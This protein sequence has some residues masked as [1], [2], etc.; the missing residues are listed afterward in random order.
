[1]S[2]SPLALILAQAVFVWVDKAGV[3]HYTNDRSSIPRG[4]KVTQTEGDEIST[5]EVGAPSPGP[6]AAPAVPPQA[7]EESPA[8]RRNREDAWRSAF[9]AARTAIVEIEAEVE[10]ER[11]QVEEVNGMPVTGSTVC[12]PNFR[13]GRQVYGLPQT[14]RPDNQRGRQQLE[15]NRRRLERAKEDLASLQRR[16]ANE[17]V[18]LEWRQ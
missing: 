7:N 17:S 2:W 9:R 11:K 8:E 12:R 1:M 5:I 10:A 13:A 18:P 6:Q 16:A 14:C 3:E 15:K 4:A